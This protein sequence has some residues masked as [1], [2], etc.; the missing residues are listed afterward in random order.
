M[1]LTEL[2]ISSILLHPNINKTHSYSIRPVKETEQVSLAKTD[3]SNVSLSFYLSQAPLSFEVQIIMEY[4]DLGNLRGAFGPLKSAQPLNYRAVLDIALDVAKGMQHLHSCNVIHT[5]LKAPNILLQSSSDV[6][7]GFVAKIADF[8][9]SLSK[10]DAL[11]SHVHGF[12]HGTK[13]HMAPEIL[14]GN[15]SHSNASDVYSFSILMFEIYRGIDA[16]SDMF[17]LNFDEMVILNNHRP[18]F[19]PGTPRGYEDLA[20]ACWSHDPKSRPSFDAIVSALTSLR[21]DEGGETSPLD[22]SSSLIIVHPAVDNSE[23]APVTRVAQRPQ[24][25]QP[26]QAQPKRELTT[27]DKAFWEA[28]FNY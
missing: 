6:A 24:S 16:F 28:V 15:G 8:G 27:N 19:P 10:D 25:G 7:K 22:F 1:A 9:L 20:A 18:S 13:S 17:H 23:P 2:A 5:D 3:N 21:E 12:R 14:S 4:C 11:A 26:I